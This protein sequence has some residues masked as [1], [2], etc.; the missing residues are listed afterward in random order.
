MIVR[1]IL[2]R[3]NGC[4]RNGGIEMPHLKNDNLNMEIGYVMVGRKYQLYVQEGKERQYYGTLIQGK[5]MKLL[6]LLEQWDKA[7]GSDGDIVS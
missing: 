5:G 6:E 1:L 3:G 7:G 4:W 2:R